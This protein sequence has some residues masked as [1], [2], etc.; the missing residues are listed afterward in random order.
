M[1][2]MLFI[3]TNHNLSPL[4]TVNDPLINSLS[5]TLP[6]VLEW[7]TLDFGFHVE[8][9]L[10]PAMS[11][12]QGRIVREVLRA[13]FPERYQSMPLG[14]AIRRLHRTARVY[15]DHTTLIDPNTGETWPTLMPRPRPPATTAT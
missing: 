14:E 8:H 2:V 10:F 1:I 7:L 4:S 6:R 13:Q 12:R 15:L 9:H 5:V 11:H 3:V